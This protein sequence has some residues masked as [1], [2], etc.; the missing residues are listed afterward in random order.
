MY[1]KRSIFFSRERQMFC[2]SDVNTGLI[3]LVGPISSSDLSSITVNREPLMIS[4]GPRSTAPSI[5]GN[6][7]D[8]STQNT[9]TYRHSKFSLADVQIVSPVHTGF[10]LPGNTD[11]PQAELILSFS[12]NSQ[13]SSLSTASGVLICFPI[14]ISTPANHDTYLDN[15]IQNDSTIAVV[16]TLE[17]LFYSS[18]NDTSQ[19]SFGYRTCFE[20]V[21]GNQSVQ[22]NSL[23]VNV[24]PNGIHLAPT[25]YQQLFS[26]L[27]QQLTTYQVPPGLRG[28]DATIRL[29]TIT[30]DGNK[31]PTQ[32]DTNGVIY[33]SPLS[34]CSD[35]F[36]NR[37]EYFSKPPR[38][39]SSVKPSGKIVV[40][41]TCPT[42]N[43]YKCIPFDQLRDVN[44][45]YVKA[46]DGK[47]LDDYIKKGDTPSSKS[48]ESNDTSIPPSGM[49]MVE[50]E[51]LVG[52]IAAGL[53]ALTAIIWIGVKLSNSNE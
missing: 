37:F 17:S 52:G 46:S 14:Y 8:D 26:L 31:V 28:G 53:V 39:P 11:T 12:S 6:R 40:S 3:Q 36:K 27:Q 25:T 7:I 38:L 42:V 13:A 2:P 45:G 41:G 23:F 4:F 24:Y 20:T 18:A 19:T 48:N 33:F 29:Y 50:I 49:S 32:I 21:D 51:E 35:D 34:T 30:D 16:P 10:N 22:S 9:C 15:V 43:Q 1:Q 44:D 5:V 47:C